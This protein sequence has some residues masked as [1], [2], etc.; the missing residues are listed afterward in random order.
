MQRIM[1]IGSSGSGK[2]TLARTVGERLGLPVFHMDREVHWL[3]GWQDRPEAEKTARVKEIIAKDQ[4]VFEGG[5]SKSYA[6]RLARADMLIWL[7]IPV[8]VR[9]WRV[10]RRS[11][12]DRGTTRPDL[13]E[14]CPE[15]LDMLPEFLGFILRTRAASRRKQGAAFRNARC[16]K[17]RLQRPR[18]VARFLA[19]L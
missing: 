16:P 18:D 6:D 7:D 14:D 8:V 15:R 13:A 4:W 9:L 1:I 3:P 19:S 17:Q 11:L 12:R 5:H 10:I 2:S